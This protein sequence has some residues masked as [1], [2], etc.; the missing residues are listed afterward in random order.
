MLDG[1]YRARDK[2]FLISY[3]FSIVSFHN[4][5]KL[6]SPIYYCSWV[7]TTTKKGDEQKYERRRIQR[8]EKL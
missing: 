6:I 4:I 2:L 3:L 7:K 5:D 8:L 1:L